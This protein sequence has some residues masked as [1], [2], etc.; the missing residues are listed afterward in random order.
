MKERDIRVIIVEPFGQARICTIKN[1]LHTLQRIVEGYIA[2][3]PLLKEENLV[4]IYNRDILMYLEEKNKIS[5][6]VSG[7]IIVAGGDYSNGEFVSL[8]DSQIENYFKIFS[9]TEEHYLSENKITYSYSKMPMLFK[10]IK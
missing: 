2:V 9:D 5:E 8:T 4:V 3:L 10:R 7:T 6:L 1:D